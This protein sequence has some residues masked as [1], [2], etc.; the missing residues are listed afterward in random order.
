MNGELPDR[1][2]P[3]RPK[4]VL[5]RVK[6]AR[7][8]FDWSINPY[9]GCGHGCHFCYARQTHTYLG[10]HTDDSFRNNIFVKRE[11]AEVLRAELKRGKW[12]GGGVVVGTA[13]DPYQQLE[14]KLKVTR[15][16]LEVLEEFGVPCSITTRS[17]LIL[18][19]LDILTQMKVN[20]VSV[21][22]STL[23]EDIWRKTEPS[24]PHPKQRFKTVRRLNEAG[25]PAGVFLAPI[26]PYITDTDEQLRELAQ[27]AAESG[28]LFLVPSVLRLK[29]EV[30]S[31]FFRQMQPSFPA[32][33]PRLVRLYGEK[34]VTPEEYRIPLLERVRQYIEE[35]GLS[36]QETR[37][38]IQPA[39]SESSVRESPVQL[40][41]F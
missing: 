5:N 13:T 35:V 1:W 9:R 19:D 3:A 28:A 34:T 36:P 11:A 2:F 7:M 8:P 33:Y 26:I 20:A 39:K 15:S 4:S 23:D 29:P 30:K 38:E 10:F 14:G 31:W 22:V 40:S 6:E 16:I 21:S 24:S 27:A 25:V 32:Q 12:K 37:M 17:P 41:L 18:R